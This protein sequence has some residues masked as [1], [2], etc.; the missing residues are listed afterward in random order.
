MTASLTKGMK[1]N[2]KALSKLVLLTGVHALVPEYLLLVTPFSLK[3]V[4]F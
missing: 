1:W 3:N 4:P 2:K